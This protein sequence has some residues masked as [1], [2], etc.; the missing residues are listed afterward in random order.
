MDAGGLALFA[1]AGAV[2]ALA[3]GPSPVAAGLLATLSGIG[4]GILR[5]LLVVEVPIGAPG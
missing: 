5:D 2:R 1:M 3:F 4:G